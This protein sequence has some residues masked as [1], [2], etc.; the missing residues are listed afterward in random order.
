MK[1]SNKEIYMNNKTR[2]KPCRFCNND[3]VALLNVMPSGNDK[4]A[5]WCEV[6]G[7]YGPTAKTHKTAIKRWNNGINL[8]KKADKQ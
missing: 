1:D 7:A 5:V 4:V 2:I 6:C 3:S 8:N